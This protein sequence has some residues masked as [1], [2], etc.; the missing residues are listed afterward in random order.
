MLSPQVT[1]LLDAH[2]DER[3]GGTGETSDWDAARRLASRRAVLL[4]GGLTP[5]NI[6]DAIARVQPYGVDVSSGV[7]ASPGIKDSK[8]L[9]AL[10]RA[11][12]ATEHQ[13]ARS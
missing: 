13:P 5:E 4:A 12:H 10:F 8:R 3:R 7:E 6:G 11:I 9:T 2:D 1:L